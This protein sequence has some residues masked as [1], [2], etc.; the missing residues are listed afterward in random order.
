[1]E[2]R[3]SEVEKM[4]VHMVVVL[5]CLLFLSGCSAL[6]NCRW[7]ER[8]VTARG[9]VIE[10]G[11]EIV[12]ADVTVGAS[13]GSLLW[14]SLDRIIAG[15]SLKGHVTSITL[16]S[17]DDPTRVLL[18]IPIDSDLSSFLSSGSIMQRP[19]D[20]GPDLGGLFE[21]VAA[22]HGVIEITTD[23]PSR[24]HVSI[25]LEVNHQTDWTRPGNCY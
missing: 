8:S 23:L 15:A 5:P 12:S 20:I 2:V 10:G 19:G 1:M 7:E 18:A 4:R 13:R 24:D 11:V 25:P 3:Y 17:S 21:V 22:N 9:V 14:K 16:V 6:S